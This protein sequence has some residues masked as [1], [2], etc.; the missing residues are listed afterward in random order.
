VS[1]VIDA[2]SIDTDIEDRDEHLRSADL[3]DTE[4]Y[5]TMTFKSTSFKKNGDKKYTLTGD[6]TMHGVT[7]QVTLEAVANNTFDTYSKKNVTGFRVTGVIKRLDYG[8]ATT[9]PTAMLSD[10]VKLMA[11]IVVVRN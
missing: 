2:K 10:E 9:T 3:F 5:P 7:K 6:F 8:I 11:N 1:L 4:K